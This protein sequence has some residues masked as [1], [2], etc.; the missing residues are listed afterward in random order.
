[1]INDEKKLLRDSIKSYRRALPYEEKS[2]LDRAVFENLL[3]GGELSRHKLVLCYISTDIEVDTKCILSYC[4]DNGVSVAVPCCTGR[5]KMDFFYYNRD[6]ITEVSGYG[7]TEPVPYK[8]TMVTDFDD[9]LCIVPALAYDKKG[10]RLG[11]GGGFYDTF[12]GKH[13]NMTTLGICYSGNILD[14]VPA[15]PHDRRVDILITDKFT[16]ALSN[17]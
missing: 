15:E 14:T 11:Y 17:G 3:A 8:N 9:S 16:E 1:M 4:L 5:R 2:K 6:S 13:E 10:Y 7:I 12:I